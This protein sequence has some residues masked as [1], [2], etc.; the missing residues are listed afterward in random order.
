MRKLLYV[1]W[2]YIFKHLRNCKY[3]QSVQPCNFKT[4][5]MQV[6]DHLNCDCKKCKTDLKIKENIDWN[7]K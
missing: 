5:S 3:C 2:D 7:K 6:F 1:N 4:L